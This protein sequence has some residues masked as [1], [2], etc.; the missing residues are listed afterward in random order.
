[1]THQNLSHGLGT[2]RTAMPGTKSSRK[3]LGNSHCYKLRM[4]SRIRGD[5]TPDGLLDCEGYTSKEL[6]QAKSF[7][8]TKGLQSKASKWYTWMSAHQKRDP[9]QH[10][11]TVGVQQR[12]IYYTMSGVER[13]S[14]KYWQSRA[15]PPE[16]TKI[17]RFLVQRHR[18]Q[19]TST[20]VRTASSSAVAV[21]DVAST[22]ISEA[23]EKANEE[24]KRL[25]LKCRNR[26]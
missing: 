26:D 18:A 25:R 7:F 11:I 3:R 6:R 10:I 21:S 12:R 23:V 1:M 13:G 14:R 5:Y 9:H 15:E 16:Q 24:L 17:G 8:T 22:S 2:G 19:V 4:W 20:P